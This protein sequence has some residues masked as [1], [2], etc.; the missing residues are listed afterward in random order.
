VTNSVEKYVRKTLR[1]DEPLAVGD[2]VYLNSGGPGMTVEVVQKTRANCIWFD[3][4]GRMRS[5]NFGLAM[6]TRIRSRSDG[7]SAGI[8]LIGDLKDDQ[9]E[10]SE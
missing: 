6:L 9:A 8:I 5:H 1:L 2:V 7:K 10:A 3:K 4:S